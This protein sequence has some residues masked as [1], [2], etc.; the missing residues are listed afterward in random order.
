M[1]AAAIAEV[2]LGVDA[3]RRSLESVA[4]PLQTAHEPGDTH[5]A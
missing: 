2:L 4:K 3:E 1:I 5:A